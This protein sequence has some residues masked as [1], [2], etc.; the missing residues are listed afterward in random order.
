M[1][2]TTEHPT[3]KLRN[4]MKAREWWNDDEESAYVQSV[5]KQVLKQISESEKM[6]KPQ[7]QEMFR[8]VYDVQPQHL[9]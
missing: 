1:W 2:N 8:D 9:K 4:Y 7:W 6:P 3:T 5:R